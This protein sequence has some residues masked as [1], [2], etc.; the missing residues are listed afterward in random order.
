MH[1]YTRTG[2][3]GE[4]SLCDGQRVPK[5]SPRVN[6]YGTVDELMAC[7]GIVLAS[8][9][10]EESVTLVQHIQRDLMTMAS[11]LAMPLESARFLRRRIQDH[12][13]LAL[14][15]AIDGLEQQMWPASGA[16][17]PV[18]PG[19]PQAVAALHLAR[20]VC[21]RA[22]RLVVPLAR[23]G[24]TDWKNVRYLNRLSDLL[25]VLACAVNRRNGKVDATP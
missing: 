14:E 7:L 21:R 3:A 9:P 15:V 24:E 1:I 25:F 4:T 11:D 2:D 12:D 5:D 18:M 16:V 20:T 19:G 22:E 13:V 23:T 8:G 6:A 17:V 10:D